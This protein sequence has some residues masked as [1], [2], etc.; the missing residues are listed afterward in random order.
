MKRL[1]SKYGSGISATEVVSE[2]EKKGGILNAYT[3]EEVT[4]YWAKLPSR[5]WLSGLKISSDLMLNS[6]LSSSGDIIHLPGF[7]ST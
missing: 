2:V 3:G 7:L 1:N 6:I 5:H 4:S